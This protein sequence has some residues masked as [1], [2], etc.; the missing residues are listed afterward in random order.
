MPNPLTNVLAQVWPVCHVIDNTNL[1][2]DI[3]RR[4]LNGEDPGHGKQGY[5]LASSGSV[6]WDDLYAAMA[7]ALAKR[8]LVD[9]TSVVPASQDVLQRMASAAGCP[10]EFVA[11]MFGGK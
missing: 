8:G 2:L 11:V 5:F 7:V 9:D 3:L 1:Y 10:P 4:I 6:A